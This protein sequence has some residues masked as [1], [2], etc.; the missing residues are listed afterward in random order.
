MLNARRPETSS[1]AF[2]LI[3]LLVVIAIISL[4]VSILLPSLQK[5]K[6]LARVTVCL[7]NIR[8]ISLGC[9]IY[10]SDQD[11]YFPSSNRLWMF[12]P[13][14][15]CLGA[16]NHP[17]M[18]GGGFGVVEAED[19][20]LNPYVDGGLKIY[21]CPSDDGATNQNGKVEGLPTTYDSLGTSYYVNA[22]LRVNPNPPIDETDYIYPYAGLWGRKAEEVDRPNGKYMIYERIM[23]VS[24]DFVLP[25]HKL[26][27]ADR[28]FPTALVIGYTDAHAEF[29]PEG[30]RSQVGD[31]PG[32]GDW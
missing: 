10:T 16:S 27:S 2:T 19:R 8:Q 9:A 3:E 21:R 5:A 12:F 11:G 7:S 23:S 24:G 31:V 26:G 6:E 17:D 15:A 25:W 18:W 29:F 13:Y 4:L 14:F 22:G 1:A 30:M 28:E 20:I 32:Q